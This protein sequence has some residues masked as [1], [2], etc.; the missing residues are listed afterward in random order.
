MDF[1]TLNETEIREYFDR[2]DNI[3]FDSEEYQTFIKNASTMGFSIVYSCKDSRQ[4]SYTYGVCS[5]HSKNFNF[6]HFKFAAYNNICLD[7]G[8]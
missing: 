5:P 8:I 2:L 1:M 3:D 7:M 6:V 4:T